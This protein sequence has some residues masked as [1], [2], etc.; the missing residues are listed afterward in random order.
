MGTS[1]F[2]THLSPASSCLSPTPWVPPKTKFISHLNMAAT[3]FEKSKSS[4]ILSINMPRIQVISQIELTI[5]Q[6][7]VMLIY[8]NNTKKMLPRS[9]WRYCCLS[10]PLAHHAPTDELSLP[11]EGFEELSR[12]DDAVI[13]LSSIAPSETPAGTG[14]RNKMECNQKKWLSKLWKPMKCE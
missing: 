6:I 7:L 2:P 10:L 12:N 9:I 1:A 5:F 13:A 3:H 11:A 4:S 8:K 14:P